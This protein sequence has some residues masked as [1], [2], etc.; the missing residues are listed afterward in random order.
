V[1]CQARWRTILRAQT[2]SMPGQMRKAETRRGNKARAETRAKQGHGGTRQF[3]HSV[4]VTRQRC[5]CL[6]N[7]VTLAAG[8]SGKHFFLHSS[9]R[10]SARIPVLQCQRRHQK[11]RV[12]AAAKRQ[13]QMQ[14]S[15]QTAGAAFHSICTTRSRFSVDRVQP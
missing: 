12:M 2:S 13:S 5:I 6:L 14:R 7:G 1:V 4:F 8:S 3:A 10:K 9:L 11:A 15:V